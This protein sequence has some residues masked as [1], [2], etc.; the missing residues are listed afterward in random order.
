VNN[1][2]EFSARTP[3][4][5]QSK[6]LEELQSFGSALTQLIVLAEACGNKKLLN[7][8]CIIKRDLNKEL[9]RRCKITTR[10]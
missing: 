1:I 4:G 2:L 9:G 6:S 8:Y 5:L 7:G 10:G 3:E